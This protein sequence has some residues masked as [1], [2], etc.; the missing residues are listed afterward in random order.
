MNSLTK[1]WEEV[2]RLLEDGLSIIPVRDKQI[3]DFAAKT[4]YYKWKEFQTRRITQGE[5]WQMME[6]KK[7][8][9]V[10]LVCGKI[11]GD[12]ELID[13]DSKFYE[14]ISIRLFNEIKSLRPDLY[15]KLRIHKTPSG[16]YHILYRIADGSPEGNQKLAS[17]LKTEEEIQRDIQSGQKKPQ[18]SVNFLETRGEGGFA[19]MP[20]SMNYIVHVDKPIP[21]ISWLDRCELIAICKS[22][23]QVIIPAKTRP[24][25]KTKSSIYTENPFDDYNK[26]GD[27]FSLLS[28]Y[29]WQLHQHQNSERYY[30]VRPGKNKGVSAS[31]T[32]IDKLFYPFSTSTD[33]ESEKSY[34]P[35]D[36]LITLKFNGDNK[37]AYKW[38]CDNGFGKVSP[39]VEKNIIKKQAYNNG[40]IPANFSNDAKKTFEDLKIKITETMPY[41]IFWEYDDNG[42]LK[43]SREDLYNVANSLGFKLFNQTKLVRINGSV[44]TEQS[45]TDFFD[46]IKCYIWEEE[47]DVYKDICNAFE[48]FLQSSGRF[49]VSRLRDVDKSLIMNDDRDYSYKFYK[50]GFIKISASGVDFY[51]YKD[52]TGLVWEHKVQ[53]REWKASTVHNTV[54]EQFLHNAVGLDDYTR[55]LIGYLSHDYKQ[56]SSGY[57]IVMTEKVPDPKDGGGSGKNVF[58]NMFKYTN[59]IKTVPGSQVKFD[60]NFLQPWNYQRIYFLADIPKKID[61][62]FLKEMATGT[63]IHK[64]LYKDQVDV[65]SEDMPKILLNTNYSYEETDG[66]LARRIR[67]LEFNPFYTLRGGVDEVHG[68]MFPQDFTEDDWTGYDHIISD[69]LTLLFKANGKL[70]KTELSEGGW[71]KKFQ[72]QYGEPT[73]QFIIDNIPDWVHLGFVSNKKFNDQYISFANDLDIPAKYRISAKQMANA[74][75]DYGTK[76]NIEIDVSVINRKNSIVQRGKHFG[77]KSEENSVF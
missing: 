56:E 32:K 45:E 23:N 30:F 62:L 18:K 60:E 17:R 54:F 73:H 41:G 44:I 66:G 3:G 24:D 68:K 2:K 43:I 74:L 4:P 29:G 14:G 13:I 7:T 36:L 8:E 61:W 11:S 52:I 5:L 48:S 77:S 70:E 72:M 39:R 51:T 27:I 76:N 20:P 47:A 55:R 22:F 33:L 10:A 57:I 69:C 25:S 46:T 67:H 42:K 6:D 16:G 71:D 64:R 38:L 34:M 53:S 28:E 19:L 50:N 1:V 59:T 9:A 21:L 63:G 40:S 15:N 31:M 37:Y 49:T 58:G 26:N 35:V 75:K 12:L 65:P